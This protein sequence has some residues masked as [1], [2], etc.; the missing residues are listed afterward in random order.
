MIFLVLQ[1]I[2]RKHQKL[3]QC[4]LR[5][6]AMLYYQT[7]LPRKKRQTLNTVKLLGKG[8]LLSQ[9]SHEWSSFLIIICYVYWHIVFELKPLNQTAVGTTQSQIKQNSTFLKKLGFSTVGTS[10]DPCAYDCK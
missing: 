4:L 2:C 10:T 3:N 5:S 1:E 6:L 9:V 8:S 7:I